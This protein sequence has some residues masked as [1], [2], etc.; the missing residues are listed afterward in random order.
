MILAASDPTAVET[1]A[2]AVRAGRPVV[3][4]TD[5]VY[6][7]AALAADS[8]AIDALFELKNRPAERAI[9]VL[10]ADTAQAATIAH[11]TRDE[12]LLMDRFWPGALTVVVHRRTEVLA[13]GPADGTIGLRSPDDQFALALLRAVGPLATT[14][15]NLSGEPTPTHAATA[16]ASLTGEVQWAVDG[17]VRS[18]SAS[19]V[20]R[21]GPDGP[22]ILRAGPIGEAEISSALA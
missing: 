19:T 1:L 18:G 14:S 4:P 13:I 7:L 16:V 3:M 5:T 21:I 20:V 2:D 10:V 22:E 12:R 9:A 17:G 11:T 6:G 8:A 15:A